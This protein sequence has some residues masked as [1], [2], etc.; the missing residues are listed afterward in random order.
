MSNYFENHPIYNWGGGEEDLKKVLI[1]YDK[2]I[3]K[4]FPIKKKNWDIKVLEIWFW[5]GKFASFCNK[6]WFDYTWIDIDDYFLEKCQKWFPN[7]KFLKI[8][9]QEYCENH[10]NEYDII[11]LAHVFEHLDEKQR[12]ECIIDI[13][14]M[15]K[16]WWK[17]INLMPNASCS[18]LSTHLRY[19]DITHF[20][21]YN[22]FSFSQLINSFQIFSSVNH[23][24]WYVWFSSRLNRILH[25]LCLKITKFYYLCMWITFPEIYTFEFYSVIEK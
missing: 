7:F 5:S 1:K 14:M 4:F 15:L 2:E 23:Y 17:R 8:S 3:L 16:S 10:K 12:R 20:T 21:I 11:Y 6:H 13:H 25:I 19:G 9:F 18:L 24:N 22:Y